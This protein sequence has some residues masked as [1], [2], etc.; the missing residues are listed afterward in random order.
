MFSNEYYNEFMR[1]THIIDEC[2]LKMPAQ[3]ETKL[4]VKLLQTNSFFD[5][6]NVGF[7]MQNIIV[8]VHNEMPDANCVDVVIKTNVGENGMKVIDI[9]LQKNE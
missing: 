3:M 4:D 5:I 8:N 6:T 9:F 1:Y 2:V 7:K